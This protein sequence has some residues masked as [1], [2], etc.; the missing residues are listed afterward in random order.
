MRSLALL[1]LLESHAESGRHSPLSRYP[2]RLPPTPH[3]GAISGACPRDVLCVVC[4]RDIHVAVFTD[5]SVGI[6]PAP[7][8]LHQAKPPEAYYQVRERV[9]SASIVCESI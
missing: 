3:L 8:Q 5:I 1:A 4:G 9:V 2:P 7:G 6:A